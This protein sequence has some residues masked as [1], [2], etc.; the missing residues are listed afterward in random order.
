MVSPPVGNQLLDRFACLQECS[1]QSHCYVV[2]L[3]LDKLPESGGNVRLCDVDVIPGSHAPLPFD[4][5][6]RPVFSPVALLSRVGTLPQESP[7]PPHGPCL[8]LAESTSLLLPH[9]E[10]RPGPLHREDRY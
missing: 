2:R 10:E 6:Q 1:L 8:R 4:T 5:M 9:L 3:V 7:E